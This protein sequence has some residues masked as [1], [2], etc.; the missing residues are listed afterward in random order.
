MLQ[1][2]TGGGGS[3]L[4]VELDVPEGID[5]TELIK[6]IRRM[7]VGA[8]DYHRALGGHGLKIAELEILEESAVPAGVPNG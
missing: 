2:E 5:H 4:I 6:R 1:E 3:G 7:A 8:D